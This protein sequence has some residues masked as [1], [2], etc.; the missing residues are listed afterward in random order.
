M[1]LRPHLD[2]EQKCSAS[3]RLR[4]TPWVNGFRRTDLARVEVLY[5][6]KRQ[7]HVFRG[8]LVHFCE[9][10]SHKW[11]DSEESFADLGFPTAS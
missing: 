9:Q 6:D 3:V 10:L 4:I 7:S 5:C 11:V 1:S 2:A 8:D